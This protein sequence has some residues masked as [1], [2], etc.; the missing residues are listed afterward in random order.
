MLHGE[1]IELQDEVKALNRQLTDVNER[2]EYASQEADT[3]QT[4]AEMP[5]GYPDDSPQT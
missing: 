5:G 3:A 2:M 4:G 1:S